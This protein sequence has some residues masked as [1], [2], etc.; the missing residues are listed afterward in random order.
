LFVLGLGSL[1]SF[2]LLNVSR[3][4]E[5]EGNEYQVSGTSDRFHVR[6]IGERFRFGENWKKFLSHIDDERVTASE[7]ALKALL[8][9]DN[10][11]GL[12]FLDIGSGSG[13]SSLSARRLGAQVVSFDF[14]PSS[15]AATQLLKER[16]IPD[17]RDWNVRQGSVLDVEFM[18]SLGKFDIVYSWGVLHHT[19]DMWKAI[20]SAAKSVGRGGRL[21]IALYNDDGISSSLW[22]YEKRLYVHSPKLMQMVLIAVFGTM[23]LGRSE[24]A[25]VVMARSG[26]LRSELG[27][28]EPRRGMSVWHDVVDWVGGYPFEYARPGDVFTF[29][30]P[31]GFELELLVTSPGA[32]ANNEFVFRHL[33]RDSGQN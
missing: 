22:R 14:D 33:D 13:L 2:L 1:I 6:E 29:L 12:T 32:G 25:R 7:N 18:N 15:V 30:R 8:G 19:G 24:L 11:A 16:C 5:V 26:A 21:A 23:S 20:A 27:G 28:R 17:D 31:L 10:L 9:M 3:H 4:K